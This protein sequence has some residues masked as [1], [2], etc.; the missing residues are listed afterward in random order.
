MALPVDAKVGPYQILGSIGSGGMGEVYRARDLRL[1]RDVAIK[2]LR[3]DV[4]RDADLVRRF[5]MEAKAVGALNHPNILT[6][7]DTGAFEGLPYLVSELLQGAT[8]RDR[9]QS[10]PLDVRKAVEYGIQIARGLAAAHE[11]G[12]VH[13]DLKP[14]NLFVTTGGVVKILDFGIAKLTHPEEHP[15]GTDVETASHTTPGT[16]IGTRGYMSPEQVRGL[17]ADARSDLF[18]FGAVL[19]EML[20]GNRAFKGATLAD[21][22]SAVLNLDPTPELLASGRIPR[23]L[24]RIVA[25]CLEKSR[26]DRFQTAR[27]LASAL[28]FTPDD[29]KGDT[30]KAFEHSRPPR[31]SFPRAAVLPLILLGVMA[32]LASSTLQRDTSND[33]VRYQRLTF[34]LGDIMSARFAPDGGTLVYSAKWGASPMEIFTTRPSAGGSR[35]VGLKNALVLAVSARDELAILIE[36]RLWSWNLWEGTLAEAPLSGGPPRERLEGVTA[37]DWSPDGKELAVVHAVAD[38]QQIEYPIGRVLYARDAPAWFGRLRVSPSG[39]HIAFLEHSRIGDTG[40]DVKVIDL[41]SGNVKTL[42]TGFSTLDGLAWSPDGDEVWFAGQAEGGP[43]RQLHASRVS[44][45]TRMVTEFLGAMSFFD[46]SASGVVLLGRSMLWTEVRGRARGSRDEVEMPGADLSF[47]NDITPD[48]TRVLGTDIG[49]GG[50]P[51]FTA[52]LQ[53]TDGLPPVRLAEGDGQALSPDGRSILVKLRT[54][55]PKLRIEP[56]GAGQP[57]ELPLGSIMSY[58]RAVWAPS[59]K[60][61]IFAG[62][63]KNKGSRLYVQDVSDQSLPEPFTAEGIGL[64]KLGRPVSPDGK[65]IVGI[66]GDGVPELYPLDGGEPRVIPTLGYLDMPVSWSEDGRELFV[67]RYEESTPRVDRVEVA[68]GRTRPWTAHRPR[69]L[70]SMLG[71]Y[72]ILISPDG[73]SY[74]YNYVSKMS[75]LYIATGIR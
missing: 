9:L 14:E 71:D 1:S 6:V 33:R 28:E 47:L 34:Q 26:D 37:A 54:T 72:R 55:P 57:Q 25:R 3:A 4:S 29:T 65:W 31:I 21:T 11:R 17:Q 38:R 30:T 46:R 49:V 63:E 7:F 66:G 40:G 67:V 16:V 10:G 48:G 62:T 61:V 36:P 58:D 53:S 27:E 19:F 22:V 24:V 60:R 2:V 59:G 43:P 64:A 15:A 39:D 75:D 35:P 68:T 70:T 5:E 50:G 73:E 23:G 13:R 51:N 41:K 45:E 42:A 12:I 52:F 32:M 69:P 56:T 20:T 44:G 74:A 8:L 18:S